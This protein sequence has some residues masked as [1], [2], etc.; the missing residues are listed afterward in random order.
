MDNNNDNAG[1][2]VKK[3]LVIVD[4]QNDFLTGSLGTE[5]CRK[6][7]PGCVR[8]LQKEKWEKV[9]I[10]ID[11]HGEDYLNTLEGR[12]LPV[13][14]CL[15]NTWGLPRDRGRGE[16]DEARRGDPVKR[17][18]V[19]RDGEGNVRLVRFRLRYRQTDC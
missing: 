7:I 6:A 9:F 10:T 14:H 1:K 15:R 4:M 11:T 19:R 18:D 16:P 12:K 3:V 2:P 8:L 13:A 17:T 5:H